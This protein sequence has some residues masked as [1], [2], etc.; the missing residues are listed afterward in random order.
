MSD[1]IASKIKLKND[2][3]SNE[4][5]DFLFNIIEEACKKKLGIL[6]VN[7]KRDNFNL[8]ANELLITVHHN[9]AILNAEPVIGA[10]RDYEVKEYRSE[11]LINRLT[12]LQKMFEFIFKQDD[13]LQMEVL[14]TSD[15]LTFDKPGINISIDE[16][17]KT[18]E[19]L[20]DKAQLPSFHYKFK[21]EK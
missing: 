7:Y 20:I 21:W 16:F 14:L 2:Y 5:S 18:L 1:I 6:V 15:D 10:D 11:P 8:L 17:A 3:Y 12:N 9:F 4:T 19:P 13:V